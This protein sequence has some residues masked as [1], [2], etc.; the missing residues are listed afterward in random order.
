MALS[1][2]TNLLTS[3]QPLVEKEV[4]L[5]LGVDEEMTKLQSTP[6]TIEAV[7]EDAE[8]NHPEDKAVQDWLRKLKGAAYEV[9]DIL[10]ECS[11]E[12]LRWESKGQSSGS[13]KKVGTSLLYPFKNVEFRHMIYRAYDERYLSE[14]SCDR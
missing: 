12:I 6:S 4:G 3:L 9:D 13:L 1:L 2:V 5:L 7:L 10:D 11:T 8:R 14:I